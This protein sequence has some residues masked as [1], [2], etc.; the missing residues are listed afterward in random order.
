MQMKLSE[1]E[2]HFVDGLRTLTA[3]QRKAI[4]MAVTRLAVKRVSNLPPNVFPFNA[5]P[6]RKIVSR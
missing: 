2:A 5:G 1:E 4:L 6:A 3:L